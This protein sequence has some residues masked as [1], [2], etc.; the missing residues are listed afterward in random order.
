MGY[1][2]STGRYVRLG[3]GAPL[4]LAQLKKSKPT[5]DED[6]AVLQTTD[7]R[8]W[9]YRK[10]SAL[11]ADDIFVVKPA[12]G[13]GRFVLAPGFTSRIPLACS[14]ETAD[15]AILATA[16]TDFR[17]RVLRGDWGTP[18]TSFTGGSSSAIGLSSSRT[19]HTTKGDLHGA[20][21]GNVAAALT[22][23]GFR[24]GTLG[25]TIAAGTFLEGGETVR[26]DRIT[27]VFTAGAT[28][29]GLILEVHANPG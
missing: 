6:G 14:F 24:Q 2:D 22:T 19:G 11:T 29:A 12:V 28:E 26:F 10:A 15:A 5:S 9:V 13:A 7:G 17:G 3:Q 8:H 27:S 16:P 4:T 1:H 20:A 23:G 25:A 21:G 18:T